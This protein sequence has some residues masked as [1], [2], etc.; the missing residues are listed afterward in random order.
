MYEGWDTEITVKVARGAD[1]R[2][3]SKPEMRRREMLKGV[4]YCMGH[5]LYRAES[6]GLVE[7]LEFC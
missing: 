6:H 5:P 2:Y 7:P 1:W 4:G 3:D